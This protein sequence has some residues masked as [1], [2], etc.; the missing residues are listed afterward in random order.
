MKTDVAQSGTLE[1]FQGA[2]YD[3]VLKTTNPSSYHRRIPTHNTALSRKIVWKVTIRSI[4]TS[5]RTGRKGPHV[6]RESA[7]TTVR[8][9]VSS[10]E[11]VTER[12]EF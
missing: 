2:R 9:N 11:A 4:T 12:M 3:V 7:V 1:I 10:K 5:R 8:K 6:L